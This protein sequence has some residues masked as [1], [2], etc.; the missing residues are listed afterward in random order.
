MTIPNQIL[1]Y[2]KTPASHGD[3][4][5]HLNQLMQSPINIYTFLRVQKRR[6]HNLFR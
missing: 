2:K 5:Y 6:R 3:R 4:C 1:F